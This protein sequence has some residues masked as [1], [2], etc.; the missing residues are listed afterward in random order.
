MDSEY[1]CMFVVELSE[2]ASAFVAN[3]H[4]AGGAYRSMGT[5]LLEPVVGT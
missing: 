1:V 4:G 2:M 5:N 3:V